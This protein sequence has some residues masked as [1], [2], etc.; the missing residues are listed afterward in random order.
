[1]RNTNLYFFC[2]AGLAIKSFAVPSLKASVNL[3]P[4]WRWVCPSVAWQDCVCMQ[5]QVNPFA[6]LSGI[7]E[8]ASLHFTNICE[9]TVG[10]SL[11]FICQHSTFWYYL[12]VAFEHSAWDSV[13]A[14]WQ[15]PSP[16]FCCYKGP[17]AQRT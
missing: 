2:S 9:C 11:L 12:S 14:Y 10:V 15:G 16:L 8:I 5:Q 4:P 1:M 6:Q 17:L 7:F 13:S 3:R